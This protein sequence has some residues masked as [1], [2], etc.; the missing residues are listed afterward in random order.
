M[1]E[2]KKRKARRTKEQLEQDIVDALEV[3]VSKKG[4]A[5]IPVTYLI[6]E[7]GI[8]PNVFYRRYQTVS[9]I[10]NEVAKK[11]DLWVNNTINL[12]DLNTLGDKLLLS[13]SLKKLHRD[14]SDN[15][16]MQKLL[17]WE[18][19]DINSTT[20]R[21]AS[22]RDT[23]NQSLI[24]YYKQVFETSDINIQ[25]ALSILIGGVYY[26]TLHKEISTFCMIDYNSSEGAKILDK[27]LEQMVDMLYTHMN[28]KS[29]QKRM[30]LEMLAD[31]IPKKKI[32]QYMGI[33]LAEFKILTT[34]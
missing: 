7:A 18:I 10:Y 24:S 19:T 5:D 14:L 20:K 21:T 25:G 22:M 26:L 34:E 17:L 3:L 12:G 33:S 9:D 1:T 30:A 4:F 32:C 8:D 6:S 2:V 28:F 11:Y 15:V 16:V 31:D 27:T 29:N 23:M 13:Q